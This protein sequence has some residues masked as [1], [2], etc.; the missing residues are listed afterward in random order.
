MAKKTKI[1][2]A[3]LNWG[4]GHASRMIPVINELC[5]HNVEVIIGADGN[6]LNLLQNEFPQLESFVFRD[7]KISYSN[8]WFNI[9]LKTF[10]N[11]IS[12]HRLLKKIVAEKHIDVVISDNRYGLF[13]SDVM[14]VLVTHQTTP[15][16]PKQWKAF[17]EITHRILN[18]I[19]SKYNRV[20]IPD[21]ESDDNLSGKLSHGKKIKNAVFINP[22]SHLSI[23]DNT[24]VKYDV[25]VI[26]SGPE[27]YRTDFE[28][29]IIEQANKTELRVCLVRGSQLPVLTAAN[30]NID[31]INFAGSKQIGDIISQSNLLV[32]RSGYSSV[33]DIWANNIKAVVVPTPNQ[34][35]QE[36]LAE[37]LSTK[38]WINTTTQNNFSL[39][40]LNELSFDA[41]KYFQCDNILER[42]VICLLEK[43]NY[44]K[45]R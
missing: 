7:V 35:E 43:T 33:M 20:W 16:L 15:I 32:C 24:D 31:I 4:L 45:R 10:V 38:G 18:Y 1:L 9:S 26:L 44:P 34:P 14:S 2:I 21:L 13:N 29:I 11:A 3:P 36:Y 12:E 25:A 19:F 22:L 42:E 17:S 27:P 40:K 30:K 8:S 28:N 41:N 39:L 37:L 6:S 23:N 5:K